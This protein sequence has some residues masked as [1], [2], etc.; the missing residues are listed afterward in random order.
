MINHKLIPKLY[1]KQIQK[2]S[3]ATIGEFDLIDGEREQC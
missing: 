3:Y 2:N 1:Y